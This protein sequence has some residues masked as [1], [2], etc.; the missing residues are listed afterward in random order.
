MGAPEGKVDSSARIQIIVAVIGLLGVIATAV[1]SNWSSIFPKPAS[2]QPAASTSTS[3]STPA[4]K[5][6]ER[7]V[8]SSGQLVVRGTWHC[9]LDVGAED[10]TGD[11]W[12][13]EDTKV[14]RSLTPENGAVF[15]VVGI[16]DF[17]SLKFADLEHFHYSQD[18]IEANDAPENNLKKRTVVAYRTKQGRLGKFVVVDYGPDLTIRW[19]TYQK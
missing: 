18:K 6:T 3:S 17:D 8:Y 5:K 16:R 10:K 19:A 1:I 2:T 13:E 4:Q 11:F 12:W 15:F 14:E 7:A 9:D